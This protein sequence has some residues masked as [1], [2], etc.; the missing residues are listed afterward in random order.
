[1]DLNTQNSMSFLP[2]KKHKQS[3]GMSQQHPVLF[4]VW[5]HQTA[6]SAT[7]AASGRFTVLREP[8]EFL[9]PFGEGGQ[10]ELAACSNI[11]IGA[12]NQGSVMKRT[13]GYRV[14]C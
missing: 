6:V 11:L 4:A 1:M 13:I 8:E 5:M 14:T 3:R 7:N 12:Y 10:L 2:E 9:T